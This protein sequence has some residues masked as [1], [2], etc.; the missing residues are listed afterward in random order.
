M[1]QPRV[2]HAGRCVRRFAVVRALVCPSLSSA[3]SSDHMYSG[4]GTSR[5]RQLPP[6]LAAANCWAEKR[7]LFTS[8]RAVECGARS[9]ASSSSSSYTPSISSA[10]AATSGVG[11]VRGGRGGD[12]GVRRMSSLKTAP[13][14][15]ATEIDGSPRREECRK[16]DSAE[17]STASLDSK[18]TLV[19]DVAHRPISVINWKRA[20]VME[21]LAKAEVLE[22]YDDVGIRSV[23]DVFP[24]PAVMR[25]CF[26]VKN[27]NGRRQTG[28]GILNVSRKAI[29]IRDRYECQYCGSKSNL[30]IDHVIP[31]SRGGEWRYDN[32]VTACSKCNTKKGSK[33]PSECRMHP[34]RKPCVPKF[35]S[36][37]VINSVAETVITGKAFPLEWASYMPRPEKFFEA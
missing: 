14:R 17:L 34:R 28:H 26:Y 12:G 1:R 32:L 11:R 8:H 6:R 9:S 15:D 23:N 30:T 24:L 31:S 36:V 33:L 4:S 35:F 16:E 22:Y 20:L 5:G 27:L 37:G 2:Q 19:L 13:P 21:M 10:A 29:F 3:N 18:K 25:V 7:G